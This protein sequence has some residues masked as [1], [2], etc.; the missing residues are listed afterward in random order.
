MSLLVFLLVATILP[1]SVVALSPADTST[2]NSTEK[3]ESTPLAR[4][5]STIQQ[6]NPDAIQSN[7][8]LSSLQKWLASRLSSRLTGS[9]IKLE[10]GQYEK[11]HSVLG[12]RYDDLLSKYVDVSE[13]TDGTHDD[14][15]AKTLKNT[16]QSQR[17]YVSKAQ[18]YRKLHDRYQRAKQHGNDKRARRIAHELD[19]LAK[20][21]NRSSGNVT[22]DYNQLSDST[23]VSTVSEKRRIQNITR[24]ISQQQASV[25]EKEFDHTNLTVSLDSHEASFLDPIQLTGRLTDENGT[26]IENQSIRLQLGGN[27]SKRVSNRTDESGNFTLTARPSVLTLG[28]HALRI[29]YAP[30]NSSIY[31]GSNTTV[32]VNISQDS[33]TI[34]ISDRTKWTRYNHTTSVSGHVRAEGI[35]AR[36]VPVAVYIGDERLGTTRTAPNGS[37]SVAPPLPANVSAG[38]HQLHIAFPFS[39]RALTAKNATAPITVAATPTELTLT[40]TTGGTQNA[41]LSGRLRTRDGTSLPNQPIFFFANGTKV[42]S[43]QT[44]K[45]GTYRVS[46]DNPSRAVSEDGKM[47]LVARFNGHKKSVKSARASTV[48]TVDV[49]DTGLLS[50]KLRKWLLGIGAITLT[51]LGGFFLW[52]SNTRGGNDTDEYTQAS[53]DG[54]VTTVSD[55]SVD[56]LSSPTA[57]IFLD[58]ARSALDAGEFETAIK[59]GYAA[60]RDRFGGVVPETASTHWEFY[61]ACREAKLT[62]ETLATIGDV[63]ELY[64]KAAFAAEQVSGGT[65]TTAIG[66][67]SSLVDD[68]QEPD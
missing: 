18:R 52:R 22:T 38:K 51:M 29:E 65:A 31:L 59:M 4:N 1:V 33:G 36:D 8:D 25:R 11:A 55:E 60:T 46:F 16:Q 61:N 32:S 6:E 2:I 24:N 13:N 17:T 27:R 48:I 3:I 57:P 64:E 68:E 28:S 39:N 5:N 35:V 9:T 41:S 40:E 67:V 53:T 43:A 54:V 58:R 42:A 12:N 14:K 66:A 34:S 62:D 15:L 30:Q 63:T 37:F 19:R 10:K 20:G 45:N 44:D 21:I 47:T 49:H 56:A 26:G 50:Q 23:N 7:G